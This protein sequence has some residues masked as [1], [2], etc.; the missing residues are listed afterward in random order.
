[1]VALESCW[2][3]SLFLVLFFMKKNAHKLNKP[4]AIWEQISTQINTSFSKQDAP[5][6][7]IYILK[8][9]HTFGE[10]SLAIFSNKASQKKTRKWIVVLSDFENLQ[11]N[12]LFW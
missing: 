6:S 5:Q 1:M 10:S 3:T 12:A 4:Q 2:S 8:M 9:L 11:S 7:K